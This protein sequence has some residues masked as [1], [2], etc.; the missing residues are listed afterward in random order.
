MS[1]MKR[2]LVALAT[3]GGVAFFTPEGRFVG[4]KSVPPPA[5]GRRSWRK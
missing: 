5:R 1:A 3:P 4:K 2:G